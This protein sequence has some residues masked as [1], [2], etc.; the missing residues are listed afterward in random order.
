MNI[1]IYP[2]K[3]D[4]VTDLADANERLPVM[5]ID[6]SNVT[7]TRTPKRFKKIIESVPLL[8]TTL[9]VTGFSLRHQRFLVNKYDAQKVARKICGHRFK[10]RLDDYF[11]FTPMLAPAILDMADIASAHPT[12]LRNKL[13]ITT[14]F[15]TIVTA[16]LL[17]NSIKDLRPDGRGRNAF[18]SGHTAIAFAGAALLDKEYGV[19]HP[20]VKV[21]GYGVASA[22]GMVRVFNNRHWISDVLGG[23]GVGMLN[24]DFAYLMNKR[25][26]AKTVKINKLLN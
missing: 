9:F 21:L 17:K 23:A 8:P 5:A 7:Q 3:K 1:T 18:P 26:L 22:V 14:T 6:S 16:H 13:I 12:A 2:A 20:W 10:T 15:T 24:T 19:N 25:K 4:S 11:Q